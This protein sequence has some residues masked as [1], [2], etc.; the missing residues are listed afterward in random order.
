M[1]IG[2]RPSQEKDPDPSIIPNSNTAIKAVVL[3]MDEEEKK[4]FLDFGI[5]FFF[6]LKNWV[7][8]LARRQRERSLSSRRE[9]HR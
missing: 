8:C 6:I 4:T 5:L 1:K 9:G 3:C 2:I 7:E